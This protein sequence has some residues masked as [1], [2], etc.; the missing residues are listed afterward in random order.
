MPKDATKSEAHRR[1]SAR[2]DADKAAHAKRAAAAKR[3]VAGYKSAKK[4][5]T[6]GT[7]FAIRAKKKSAIKLK[8]KTGFFGRLKAGI[9]ALTADNNQRSERIKAQTG[10]KTDIDKVRAKVKKKMKEI[11]L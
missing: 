4:V 7:A 1:A 8:K 9:K 2:L 5:T 11:G 3:A 10:I 6:T